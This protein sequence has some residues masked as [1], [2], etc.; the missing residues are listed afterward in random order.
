MQLGGETSTLWM[1]DDLGS[2]VQRPQF[3]GSLQPTEHCTSEPARMLFSN[4]K[5]Q[6]HDQAATREVPHSRR[7]AGSRVPH[8]CGSG[9]VSA[10]R[11]SMGL[12]DFKRPQGS[13]LR[14]RKRGK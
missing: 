5:R 11:I 3:A 4:G 1:L 10:E 2:E 13:T 8:H 9:P 7:V 6:A 14:S 12:G